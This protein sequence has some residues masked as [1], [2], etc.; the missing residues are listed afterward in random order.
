[1]IKLGLKEG[2]DLIVGTYANKVM[3]LQEKTNSYSQSPFVEFA[4]LQVYKAQ[5]K[6]KEQ[7]E[8]LDKL[9]KRDL[10]DKEK[11]RV[12]YMYGSLLMKAGK[13]TQ[14]K[15]AFEESIKADEKSAWAGL[16]KDALELVD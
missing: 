13:N 14:A 5:K 10:S 16:S 4:A 3:T 7:L 12:Q 1:M 9:V 11:S 2:D 6:D 8:L 15:A